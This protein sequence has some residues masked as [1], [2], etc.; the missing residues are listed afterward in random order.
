MGGGTGSTEFEKYFISQEKVYD[1]I[2]DQL[3]YCND[4]VSDLNLRLTKTI[5]SMVKGGKK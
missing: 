4:I 3:K 2:L 1:L 5:D